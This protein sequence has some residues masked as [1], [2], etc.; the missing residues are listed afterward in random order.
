[1]DTAAETFAQSVASMRDTIAAYAMAVDDGRTDDIVMTFCPDGSATL[2]GFEVTAGHGALRV[3]F[4][5]LQPRRPSRH[6]VVN[7]RVTDWNRHWATA[8]SDLVVLGQD[9]SG[10][11]LA[12]GPAPGPGWAIQLVGRYTDLFHHTDGRWR[13]HA[14]NLEV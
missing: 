12:P 3:M 9:G 11:A 8:I 1:V 2:P 6:L 5:G 7:T 13:F 10:S 4:A 14:R